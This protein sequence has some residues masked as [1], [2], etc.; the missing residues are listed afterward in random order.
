M[1]PGVFLTDRIMPARPSES[2]GGAGFQTA[3]VIIH[4]G[5]EPAP[6]MP[7]AAVGQQ[8]GRAVLAR[9][10]IM[11]NHIAEGNVVLLHQHRRQLGG[12][13]PGDDGVVAPHLP[14]LNPDGIHVSGTAAVRMA[15]RLVQRNMLDGPVLVHRKMPVQG[16]HGPPFQRTGMRRGVSR[17]VG[18]AVDG[19]EARMHGMGGAPRAGARGHEIA[20]DVHFPGHLGHGA[21]HGGN[22]L[23]L[24]ADGRRARGVR[25]RRQ[26]GR[27]HQKH[28]ICHQRSNIH[29]SSLDYPARAS[30]QISSQN[31]LFHPSRSTAAGKREPPRNA[32]ERPPPESGQRLPLHGV[33]PPG[34]TKP[35]HKKPH[36]RLAN[37]HFRAYTI[38]TMSTTHEA[39]KK[40]VDEIAQLCQPDS[41]YWCNGSQEENDELCNMMVEKGTFIKLNPEKRPG[42]FLA[43][44]TPSDV[45]RVEDRTFICS[46]KEEDACR[47]RL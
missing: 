4:A 42:C 1:G 40:W 33:S 21:R 20:A 19:D 44:S 6:F 27:Q 10:V 34:A 29:D 8:R 38:S 32:P 22:V 17:G 26:Q 41:I 35:P 12:T 43:R 15:P 46:E 2:G 30:K 3:P 5:D 23:N 31:R 47:S 9:P 18:R 39:A 16:T 11:G 7:R 24:E 25:T 36:G 14:H 37:G 13:V 45:A 28:R